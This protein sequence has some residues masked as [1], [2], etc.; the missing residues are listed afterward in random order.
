[1]ELFTV[2][3]NCIVLKAVGFFTVRHIHPI[4]MFAVAVTNSI[5]VELILTV[6]CFKALG[7]ML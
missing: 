7:P 2:V 5:T 1:M 3:I 4:L 6:K